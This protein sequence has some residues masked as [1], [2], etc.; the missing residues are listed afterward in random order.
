MG[1][2]MKMRG[3]EDGDSGDSSWVVRMVSSIGDERLRVTER[4]R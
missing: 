2:G 4:E 3:G 1:D